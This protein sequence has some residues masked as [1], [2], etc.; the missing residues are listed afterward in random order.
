ML[1]EWFSVGLLH[2]QRI[3]WTASSGALL[4]KIMQ[5]AL[6][7]KA[8]AARNPSPTSRAATAGFEAGRRYEEVA[9]I[10]AGQTCSSG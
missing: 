7:P 8:P 6:N 1:Q 9:P 4:Q 3:T 5:C 10:Q 2:L